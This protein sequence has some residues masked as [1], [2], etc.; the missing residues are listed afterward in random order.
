MVPNDGTRGHKRHASPRTHCA[1]ELRSANP[2]TTEVS[3]LTNFARTAPSDT[4]S[5]AGAVG[6]AVFRRVPII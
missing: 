5:L 2:T 3:M 1:D 4:R 6:E